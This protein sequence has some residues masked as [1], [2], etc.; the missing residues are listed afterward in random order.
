MGFQTTIGILN[1]AWHQ[2]EEHPEDLIKAIDQGMMPHGAQTYRD[3][4]YPAGNHGNCIVVLPS[5]HADFSQLAF[6][7]GNMLVE[8][9]ERGLSTL[10]P[11]LQRSIIEEAK[12]IIKR[13]EK[14]LE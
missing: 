4:E 10:R 8:I 11:E 2:I 3:F 7:H 12:E 9:S 1:D 5:H 13:V 6:S 14:S